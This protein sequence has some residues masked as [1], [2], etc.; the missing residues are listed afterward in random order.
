M[1]E[2]L[3]E[4]VQQQTTSGALDTST[5]STT[6][7]GTCGTRQETGPSDQ[8]PYRTGAQRGGCQTPSEAPP[9]HQ[10]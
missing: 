2:K 4:Q 1:D 5:A 7:S 10:G 8:I 3:Q 9:K 6:P